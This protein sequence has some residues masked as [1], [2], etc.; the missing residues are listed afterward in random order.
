MDIW[1]LERCWGPSVLLP[2]CSCCRTETIHVKRLRRFVSG[3]QLPGQTVQLGVD[4]VCWGYLC[5]KTAS[6]KVAG[7][8]CLCRVLFVESAMGLL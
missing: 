6:S 5:P 7:A 2:L 1:G 4:V 8:R 3:D